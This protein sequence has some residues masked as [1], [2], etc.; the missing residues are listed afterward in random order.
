MNTLIKTTLGVAAG[1]AV[2]AIA[3][4]KLRKPEV[5][6]IRNIDIEELIEDADILTIDDIYWAVETI[7]LYFIVED[8]EVP[9][10]AI[11]EA[12]I[13]RFEECTGERVIDKVGCVDSVNDWISGVTNAF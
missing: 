12:V 13:D 8:L 2:A 7:S 10:Y 9:L 6:T 4:K 11:K 5:V 3:Y 1:L